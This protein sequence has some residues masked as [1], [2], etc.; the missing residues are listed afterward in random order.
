MTFLEIVTLTRIKTDKYGHTFADFK[1]T[2][3][4]NIL[5]TSNGLGIPGRI[6]PGFIASR[7]YGP[8]NTAIPTAILVAIILYC[9][10]GVGDSR[11]GLY[12]FAAI[13]GL[14]ASAIQ[15]L[16][17]VSLAA[18][19]D[20]TS[21][22]G[23]RMRMVFSVVAFASLTGSP[24]AGALIQADGGKYMGAQIRGATSMLLGAAALIIARIGRT[25]LVLHVKT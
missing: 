10:I 1:S 17:A 15:S 11:S 2:D 20:D 19:T 6:L 18:L 16:F 4:I 9:W 22:L 25:G 7:W 12:T 24:I 8:L 21:K 13:Y 5:L 14:A 3:S 23:T